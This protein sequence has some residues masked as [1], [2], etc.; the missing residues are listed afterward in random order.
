MRS[1][2]LRVLMVAACPLPWPRGTPI[3]IHRMAEA[4]SAHGL[5]VTV[6]T[7]PLGD[8]SSPTRYRLRRVALGA[9]L[10]GAPG[11]SLKK[12]LYLDP[13]LGREIARLLRREDFD[14]IHAHHYEGLIAA[15]AARRLA[16]RL[17]LIYDAHTLLATELPQYR[18]RLPRVTLASVGIAIDRWLPRRADRIIAVTERMRAW[19]ITDAGIPAERVALIPNGVEHEHFDAPLPPAASA[20]PLRVTFAGNLAGYQRID[21]LL[22][23]FARIR[24]RRNDAELVFVTDS[25][26]TPLLA[27][28]E[29][30][31]IADSMR[32]VQADYATLPARLAE[33]AVLA[34]PRT[35]CDGLPQKLLNY[36][37]AGRPVVS[38]AG[39][40][41]ILEHERTGLVVPDGDTSAF[42]DAV[43]RLADDPAL[44]GRLAAAAKRSVVARHGWQHVAAQVADV[45][46]AMLARSGR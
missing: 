6:L 30:L 2:T 20:S 18:L 21:L 11:P 39:S 5:D 23:A 17:P 36:M 4:L 42:A 31:G 27:A 33:S 10:A 44:A 37:A 43:L 16:R 9:A 46:E 26:V 34:N 15:L 24:R 32:T 45:Y 38:F 3:R 25:D 13:L 35:Q 29:R 41:A 12:L 1:R 8:L 19:F 22:E 7:Y 40:A 28:G 14:V